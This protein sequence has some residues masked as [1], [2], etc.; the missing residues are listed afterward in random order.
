MP[1][2]VGSLRARAQPASVTMSNPAKAV[3]G[4]SHYY[5]YAKGAYARSSDKW[6]DLLKI[7]AP[8]TGMSPKCL[9]PAFSGIRIRLLF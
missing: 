8:Y 2:F 3:T 4:Y 1:R 9:G 6:S 7:V 5:L